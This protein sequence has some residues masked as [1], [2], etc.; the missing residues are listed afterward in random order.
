LFHESDLFKP[1]DRGRVRYAMLR[2]YC[3]NG[4]FIT[5]VF[6]E[7]GYSREF[8]CQA[9]GTCVFLKQITGVTISSYLVMSGDCALCLAILFP[10]GKKFFHTLLLL[11][12]ECPD[13]IDKCGP[14]S[15]FR[16]QLPFP[17][18][19]HCPGRYTENLSKR[20]GFKNSPAFLIDMFLFLFHCIL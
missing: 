8:F 20:Q 6:K 5:K 13:L 17:R 11:S 15:R 9:L 4:R 10:F 7:L 18:E 3:H 14:I 16:L 2:A 19:V 1:H 12:W